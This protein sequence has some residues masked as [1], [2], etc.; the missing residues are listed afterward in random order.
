MLALISLKAE[1]NKTRK[2]DLPPCCLNSN[3]EGKRDLYLN[4]NNI[5]Y[6]GGNIYQRKI[7]Q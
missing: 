3:G 6:I 1:M 4:L 5:V 2:K 7:K